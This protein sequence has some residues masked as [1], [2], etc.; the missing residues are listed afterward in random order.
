MVHMTQSLRNACW[1]SFEDFFSSKKIM[2][3]H[4]KLLSLSSFSSL[5][6]SDC[7]LVISS[8]NK[9][10]K[11]NPMVSSELL[12][13][14]TLC[15]LWCLLSYYEF[16]PHWDLANFIE[17]LL[18]PGIVLAFDTLFTF[19]E[20]LLKVVFIISILKMGQFAHGHGGSTW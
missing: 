12:C 18:C 13:S 10:V 8:D 14:F 15:S 4:Y 7:I 19:H 20:N 3:E 2:W 11:S 6:L 17:N 9:I 5:S 16:S 1:T